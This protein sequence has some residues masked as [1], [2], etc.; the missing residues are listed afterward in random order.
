MK[1][2]KFKDIG[3]RLKA[4]RRELNKTQRLMAIESRFSETSLK[5]YENGYKIPSPKLLIFLRDRYNANPTFI[6]TGD[7]TPFLTE[8]GQRIAS[9]I[10][11][12]PDLQQVLLEMAIHQIRYHC[13][14]V[15]Y[16][17]VNGRT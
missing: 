6:L 10:Q 14:M 8:N 2:S 17:K 11:S 5:E 15:L 1:K 3:E 12:K 13:F 4:V 9:F 16:N 7:G